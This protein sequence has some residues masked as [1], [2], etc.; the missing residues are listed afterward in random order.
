MLKSKPQPGTQTKTR[1]DLNEF[2][3][4]AR[5]NRRRLEKERKAMVDELIDAVVISI[6]DDFIHPGP[7][8]EE[9]N[10]MMAFKVWDGLD[11][12]VE[13]IYSIPD[14]NFYMHFAPADGWSV[15]DLGAPFDDEE[16]IVDKIEPYGAVV[17]AEKAGVITFN[18]PVTVY[19]LWARVTDTV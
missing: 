9:N 13:P 14:F 10:I 17:R 4:T 3:K 8:A 18:Y 16:D 6:G 7:S 19:S 15:Y 2:S 1:Y 11:E 5:A 12:P